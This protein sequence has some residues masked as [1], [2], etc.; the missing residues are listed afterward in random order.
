MQKTISLFILFLSITIQAQNRVGNG[1]DVVICKNN[2]Q[3]LD[4]Y[5]DEKFKFESSE[6]SPWAIAEE[7]VLQLKKIAPKLAPQYQERLATIK[8]EFE[9]KSDVELTDVKDSSHLFLGSGCSIKQVAVRKN[10]AVG[11]DFRFIISKK[12]WDALTPVHQAGLIMHEIVYEHFYKL[13]EK[14]SKNDSIK[15]RKVNRLLFSPATGT[16]FWTLIKD[17][18]IPIYP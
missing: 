10:L 4:F 11:K 2:T 18:E 9:Y 13:G 1:G 17:L 14:D 16:E 7:R 3:L 6:K 12:H 8:N 5:E 15:A